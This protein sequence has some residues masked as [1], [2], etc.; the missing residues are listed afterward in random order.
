MDSALLTGG[1]TGTVIVAAFIVYK[2]LYRCKF[3]STCCGREIA[4]ETSLQTPPESNPN[5]KQ[6]DVERATSGSNTE[7]SPA[8]RQEVPLA[9]PPPLSI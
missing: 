7:R 1:V 5:S 9:S 8:N 3:R 6:Q 4:I 2:L